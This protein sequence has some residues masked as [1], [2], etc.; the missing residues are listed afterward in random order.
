M[1]VYDSSADV[2]LQGTFLQKVYS[3]PMIVETTAIKKIS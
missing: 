1:P 3:S 2:K